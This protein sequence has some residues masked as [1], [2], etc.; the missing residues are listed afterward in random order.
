MNPYEKFEAE[1]ELPLSGARYVME[2][3]D[4]MEFIF[5]QYKSFG[6]Q[7]IKVYVEAIPVD[8]VEPRTLLEAQPE[9]NEGFLRQDNEEDEEGILDSSTRVLKVIMKKTMRVGRMGKEVGWLRE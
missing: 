9:D 8:F 7:V 6:K 5:E 1:V 3:D 4:D 2:G